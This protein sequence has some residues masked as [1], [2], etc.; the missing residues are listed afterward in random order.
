M[1]GANIRLVMQEHE[2]TI[3]IGFFGSE[4]AGS[5]VWRVGR[6]DQVPSVPVRQNSQQVAV[7]CLLHHR[8][9]LEHRSSTY[10]VIVQVIYLQLGFIQI[11]FPNR[12]AGHQIGFNM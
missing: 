12:S 2:H 4:G 10:T 7:A 9:H 5:D 8:L 3:M 1:L 11:L 6:F